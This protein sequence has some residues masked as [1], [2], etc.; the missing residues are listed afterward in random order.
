MSNKGHSKIRILE[1]VGEINVHR[2]TPNRTVLLDK[3]DSGNNPAVV[4]E[5]FVCRYTDTEMNDYLRAD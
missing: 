3:D 2:Q 1:I 5:K 4:Q